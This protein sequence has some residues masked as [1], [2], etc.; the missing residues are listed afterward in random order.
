MNLTLFMQVLPK[1]G[2]GWLGGFAVTM[3]SVAAV[4]LLARHGRYYQLYTLQYHK[5]QLSS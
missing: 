1:A 5:E 4:E 2:L 3:I